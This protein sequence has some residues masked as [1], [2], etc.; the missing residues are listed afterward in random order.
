MRGSRR[1]FRTGGILTDVLDLQYQT[2]VVS[3]LWTRTTRSCL[4]DLEERARQRVISP[5]CDSRWSRCLG[6]ACRHC[7]RR[8]RRNRDHRGGWNIW[9]VDM[10]LE[11]SRTWNQDLRSN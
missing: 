6:L 9:R 3:T 2:T 11:Y 7:G 5:V 1:C 8:R 10:D 4:L